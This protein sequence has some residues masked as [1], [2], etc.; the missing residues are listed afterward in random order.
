MS[1][2]K[3]SLCIA[4]VSV[5]LLTDLI[6]AIF[7]GGVNPQRRI[8]ARHTFTEDMGSGKGTERYVSECGKLLGLFENTY[9]HDLENCQYTSRPITEGTV[10]TQASGLINPND[11]VNL[12]AFKDKVSFGFEIDQSRDWDDE[13]MLRLFD[14][15]GRLLGIVRGSELI[16]SSYNYHD[17]EKNIDVQATRTPKTYYAEFSYNKA[18][19][20]YASL[21]PQPLMMSGAAFGLGFGLPVPLPSPG[22]TV[23]KTTTKPR[24]SSTRSTTSSQSSSRSSSGSKSWPDERVY[25]YVMFTVRTYEPDILPEELKEVEGIVEECRKE[26][27]SRSPYS[28]PDY[29]DLAMVVDK[30]R[31][32]YRERN[33]H[34]ANPADYRMSLKQMSVSEINKESGNYLKKHNILSIDSMTD[35]Q[36]I[37]LR[38]SI[39]DHTIGNIPGYAN[40]IKNYK[41]SRGITSYENMT[42]NELDRMERIVAELSSELS[43]K[44]QQQQQQSKTQTQ[45]KSSGKVKSTKKKSK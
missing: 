12:I 24:K 11:P 28:T 35:Q 44:Y 18:V 16:D 10:P 41:S 7:A 45:K 13:F 27:R 4:I 1:V 32:Y 31:E 43:R 15:N 33:I 30:A 37:A 29:T 42:M 25:C 5:I 19:P 39:I 34:F 8:V 9:I 14:E 38:A 40:V 36:I 3:K 22:I 23:P 17:E 26:F 20:G 21:K 2:I 6:G